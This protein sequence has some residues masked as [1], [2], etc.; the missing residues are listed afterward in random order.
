MSPTTISGCSSA[1]K[2]P[3]FAMTSI[4]T[5]AHPCFRRDSAILGL[6][7]PTELSSQHYRHVDCAM[8]R[9]ELFVRGEGTIERFVGHH[10]RAC[11]LEV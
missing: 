6:N 7:F 2:W 3:L 1:T 8:R 9:V 4:A 11:A 5:F 10:R